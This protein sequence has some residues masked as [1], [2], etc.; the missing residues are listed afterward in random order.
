MAFS[1]PER[2]GVDRETFG[3]CVA[4]VAWLGATG[5]RTIVPAGLEAGVCVAHSALSL[6][7]ARSCRGQARGR[8]VN[9][10]AAAGVQLLSAKEHFSDRTRTPAVVTANPEHEPPPGFEL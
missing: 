2:A 10:P 7:D 9:R 5:R 8:G 1:A 4:P 6:V 3:P